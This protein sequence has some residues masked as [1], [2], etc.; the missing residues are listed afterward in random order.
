[1][2]SEF[3]GSE[4]LPSAVPKILSQH[5]G[6]RKVLRGISKRVSEHILKTTGKF[7]PVG[8]GELCFRLKIAVFRTEYCFK[9]VGGNSRS[10]W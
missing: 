3:A 9:M 7:F 6:N 8:S 1:M 5:G 2:N 4:T 10:K